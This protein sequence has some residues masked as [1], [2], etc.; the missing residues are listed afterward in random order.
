[1]NHINKINSIAPLKLTRL[2]INYIWFEFDENAELLKKVYDHINFD[3]GDTEELLLRT[4][5]RQQIK[6]LTFN[7]ITTIK[8]G[9]VQ[10][11]LTF[12]NRKSLQFH[13]DINNVPV[14]L[15]D[16]SEIDSYFK[17]MLNTLN[18]RISFCKDLING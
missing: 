3:L 4:N 7:V 15:I 1:L 5:N 6:A 14:E 12:E 10:N 18:Q 8:S 9:T 16:S 11:Q 13:L 2:A 17:E